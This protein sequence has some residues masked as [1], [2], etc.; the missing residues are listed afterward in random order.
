MADICD[1][2]IKVHGPKNACYAFMGSTS[3]YDE[4]EILSESGNDKNYEL[5]FKGCCKWGIDMYCHDF[6]GEKPVALPRDANEA[7]A[8]AEDLYW[9]HTVKER[10]EMFG[11]EVWCN[12]GSS[13]TFESA[14][15]KILES[16]ELTIDDLKDNDEFNPYMYEH[17]NCGKEIFDEM[18]EEINIPFSFSNF[19]DEDDDWDDEEE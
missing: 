17:Y 15:A 16:G 13:E 12:S 5:T 10:S 14:I 8:Q 2:K 1:Y 6:K 11:V 18:S 9:Y 7:Y 19:E 3:T 4:R